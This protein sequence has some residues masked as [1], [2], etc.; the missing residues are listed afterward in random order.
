M[1]LNNQQAVFDEVG[2][3][4][5]SYSNKKSAC[6]LYKKSSQDNITCF[7]CRK[8]GHKAYVCNLRKDLNSSRSKTI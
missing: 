8:I 6:K 4:Y 7:I 3:G 2:L 5:R 1:I